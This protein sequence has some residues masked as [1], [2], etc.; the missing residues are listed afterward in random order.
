MP[1]EVLKAGEGHALRLGNVQMV[2][3]EDGSH[4]RETL[5][6]AEFEVSSQGRDTPPP[7]IHH[8]HEEGLYILDGELEFLV[9]KQT[10]RAGPGTFVMVPIGVPHTFR[11]PTDK[12]ARFLG[13]FTPRRYLNYF[14]ELSQLFEA[15]ASPT[16][17]Q[18]A[19]LMARYD[20]EVVS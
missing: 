10:V 13:T 5:G 3:K 11:N 17:Q 8:A 12:P 7:H 4:T 9:G 20:T 1:A 6:L 16:P 14:V 18:R 2:V 15:T 19:D